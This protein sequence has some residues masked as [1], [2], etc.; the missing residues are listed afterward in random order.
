MNSSQLS[1]VRSFFLI[2][3]FRFFS[4]FLFFL[5]GVF[6]FSMSHFRSGMTFCQSLSTP[7]QFTADT[8][9]RDGVAR[10]TLSAKLS[11]LIFRPD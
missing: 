5:Q 2:P 8:L 1:E 4:F 6:K 3:F 10:D 9:V 11:R 7:L